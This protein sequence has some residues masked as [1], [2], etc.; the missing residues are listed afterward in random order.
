[1]TALMDTAFASAATV[2][3]FDCIHLQTPYHKFTI[4]ELKA[5]PLGALSKD[6]S[7]IFIWTDS[8][9]AATAMQLI[10]AYGFKFS[11]IA[12]IVN[13][14]EAL[15]VSEEEAKKSRVKLI[16]PYPWWPASETQQFTRPT[17]EQLWMATK[18]TGAALNPKYKTLPFQVIDKP[19]LSKSKSKA[20]QST[21]S[22]WNCK[23]PDLLDQVSSFLAPE[24]RIVD[25]FGDCL[26]AN[27]AV[28]TP[29]IANGFVPAMESDEGIVSDAKKAFADMGKVSLRA[30]TVKLRRSLSEDSEL[31]ETVTEVLNTA[32][33]D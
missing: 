21:D 27:A 18:G 17:C 19:E 5:F 9:N 26:H 28:L 12:A 20:R 6:D 33:T 15:P 4:D 30:L 22:E 24:S 29:T 1:M 16:Q 25:V 7:T 2:E 10:D 14:A 31:D 11:T 13:I 3:K 8:S 32:V 23:R